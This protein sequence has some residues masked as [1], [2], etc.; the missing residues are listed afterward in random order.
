[1]ANLKDIRH[2]IGSVTSIQQ[3]TKAMKMVAAAKLRRAQTNMQQA[4]PYAGR[5]RDVLF[6]LLPQID[7]QLL[8]LLEVRDEIKRTLLVV[9][10][11]DRG[12]A[13][14]FNSNILKTA[15]ARVDDLGKENTDFICI[16]R[17]GRDYFKKRGYNL[18]A[19]YTEFWNNLDFDQATEIGRQMISPYVD[20]R[21]DEVLVIFNQ[22][23]NVIRQDITED[24]LLPL[25]IEEGTQ[26][27]TSEVLF[28]PSSAA[29][30]ESLVPRHLNVQVWRYLLESYASEQAARMTAM[31]NA[32]TNA[33]EVIDALQ[34]EYN[35][36]RQAAITKEILDIVG[37]AEALAA[38]G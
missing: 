3:V 31:E 32:T 11:S 18:I 28:E 25:V 2:R 21:V 36:A 26:I 8:P 37:G 6:T 27:D 19:E 9:V 17:K 16:G 13:A 15:Q 22:F 10:T 35:K 4:R 23:F 33:N 7:R 12:M 29:V 1:M 34:L 20:G 14:G 24:Q 5:L 30:V 38:A